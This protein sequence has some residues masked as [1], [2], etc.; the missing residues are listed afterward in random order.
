MAISKI[1]KTIQEFR[2]SVIERGGP[3][4]ASRY[5]V[6]LSH[7]DQEP[8]TCYPMSVIVPGRSFVYYDHDLWGTIRKVPYK[9]G[10]TQCHMSFIVYQDWAERNYIER[11]MNT[12]IRNKQT[13]SPKDLTNLTSP[14]IME[15]ETRTTSALLG[16][17]A[18]GGP[19]S[20]D[21][22]FGTNYEDFIDYN[23][24]FGTIHIRCMNSGNPTPGPNGEPMPDAANKTIILK[25]VFPAAISQM[26]LASEG[27][28]YPSFNVTFQFNNYYYM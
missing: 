11:W 5:E 6:I 17:I 19:V 21:V 3:Q 25:E 9:R 10:Y 24:G 22:N 26:S 1:S 4:I 15:D 28:G 12:I 18:T 27:T 8:L 2:T 13:G 20:N 14:N 7:L 16:A 23:S